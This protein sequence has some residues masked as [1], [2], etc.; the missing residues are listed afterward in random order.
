MVEEDVPLQRSHEEQRGG[1][2]IADAQPSRGGGAAEVVG[3]DGEAAPRRAVALRIERQDQ[4]R[5]PGVFVHGHDDA[6]G[7]DSLG[8]GDEPLGDAAEDDARIGVRGCRRQ[9]ADAGGRLD[10]LAALHGLGEE[11]VLGVDVAEEG[12]GGDAELAGDVG[13]GGGGEAL[14]GEDAAGGGED[15]IAADARG[16]THL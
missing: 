13:E 10:D 14:G 3:D 9:I 1:A 11:G 12:G 4:R 8:E 15:L 5:A 6:G 2:R 7:D 16:A